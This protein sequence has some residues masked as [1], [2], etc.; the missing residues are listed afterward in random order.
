[1]ASWMVHLRVAEGLLQKMEDLSET[2][3]IVGNIAPDSGVPNE[4]W[5]VFTPSSELSH[6][7]HRDEKGIKVIDIGKYADS[8]LKKE[9]C[10][11]YDKKQLS[12]YLGYYD[13][14]MTDILWTTYVVTP[15]T[16]RDW[17]AYSQDQMAAVWKWKKDWYDL[18][19]LYLQKHPDFHAFDVYEG[20]VGFRNTFLD[21][22]AVD[23][24]DN[25]RQYIT[26]FYRGGRENLDREYPWLTE[27]QMDSF[28]ELAVEKIWEINTGLLAGKSKL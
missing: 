9:Q 1:M 4:D 6:Y 10:E 23:A 11:S 19:F 24:F 15:L 26:G 16:Q 2:E 7:S 20:A 12:F 8:Y 22:F 25:R 3:F 14:L 13:H 18:D 5:S 17:E 27:A 21:Y 28:V